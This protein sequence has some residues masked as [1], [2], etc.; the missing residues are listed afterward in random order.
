MAFLGALGPLLSAGIGAG[1]SAA[2]A[3][4]AGDGN[5][6]HAGNHEVDPNAFQYGGQTA[7][8]KAAS[9][10]EAQA[11]A[12]EA[13]YNAARRAGGLP[14]NPQME[15]S[16][17]QARARATEARGKA[18]AAGSN[19][20]RESNRNEQRGDA[21]QNRLGA[22]MDTRNIDAD[23]AAGEQARGRVTGALDM[24]QQAAMG[25]GP[26]AAQGML[27]QGLDK[28]IAMQRS[29]AAT[30]KAPAMQ[31][32]ELQSQ[33][34]ANAGQLGA[35]NAAQ[36]AIVKGQEQ[37]AGMAGLM[38]GSMG[39]RSGDAQAQ[40]LSLQQSS[41]QAGYQQQ[42]NAL[43]DAQQRAYEAQRQSV[44][45]QQFRAQ[46]SQQELNQR[47]AMAADTI[48]SGA[49]KDQADAKRK[50]AGIVMGGMSGAADAAA[51][52]ASGGGGTPAAAGP[53]V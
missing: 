44:R 52:F 32:A 35:Q 1:T 25:Q 45:D 17:R 43:N 22:Q 37:Q 51:K 31:R 11:N 15:E 49:A 14:P 10:A 3:A 42:Q 30:A 50:N 8:E 20:D 38:Q 47:G 53:K 28:N 29:L 33:G 39:L 24:Y 7:E 4:M 40:G 13:Q 23:R 21:A 19:V 26:S 9:D 46:Q 34:L 36:A 12:M 48:N 5:Q 27:Q 6:F 41:T 18:T 2:G 16:I